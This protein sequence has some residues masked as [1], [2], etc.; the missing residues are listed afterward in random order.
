MAFPLVAV[1]AMTKHAVE[2]LS[3]GLRRELSIYG[4]CVSALEPGA[5]KTPI[6]DKSPQQ[7][8]DGRFAHTD[9][10]DAMAAMPAFVAKELKNAKPMQVVLDA[11]I[12]A[13]EA[14]RPKAR[15]PLVGLWYLRNL[16]P[17]RL[18][19]RLAIHLTGLKTVR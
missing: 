16:I 6:W 19:D 5:I 15:Y 11:I 4:I 2:A 13:L 3:D 18:F 1:Y 12:D 9:Y 8:A 7:H 10:A 17:T 14:P